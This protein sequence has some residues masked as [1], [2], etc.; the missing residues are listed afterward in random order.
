MRP[1]PDADEACSPGLEDPRVVEALE[2]YLAALEAGE[3]PNR[4]AFLARHAEIAA[5]LAEPWTML[6]IVVW[7]TCNMLAA[8]SLVADVRADPKRYL[9]VKVSLF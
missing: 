9:R 4:Q 5:A 2:Q 8:C 3:R 6:E 7:S 1:P